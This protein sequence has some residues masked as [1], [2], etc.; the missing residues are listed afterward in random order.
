MHDADRAEYLAT[1]CVQCC[2]FKSV[3][4]G[5]QGYIDELVFELYGLSAEERAMVR[6][7]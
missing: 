5:A 2:V 3:P 4:R 7:A 6:G 1:I